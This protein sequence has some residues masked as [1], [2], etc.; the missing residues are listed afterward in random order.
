MPFDIRDLVA[1]TTGYSGREMDQMV[2]DVT[3]KMIADSNKELVQLFDQDPDKARSYQIKTRPLTMA[4]FREAAATI[5]PQ[6]KPAE[7]Q[8]YIRWAKEME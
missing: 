8:R 1:L 2:K 3:G 7:M 4:A 5:V 6:T